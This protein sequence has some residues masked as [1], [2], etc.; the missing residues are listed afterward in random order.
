MISLVFGTRPEAIKLAP[1]AASLRRQ[2]VPFSV[3]CT[4]QHT[5]LL[6][7]I[8]GNLAGRSLKL[9]S[10][11]DVFKWLRHA[12]PLVSAALKSASA[13]VVVVQGDTMSALAGAR[14]ARNLGLTLCHV[15]AGIRS[16]NLQEPWPEEGFRREITRLAD[17]H[18]APTPTAFANLFAE[19]VPITRILVT[20]NTVVSALAAS[21]VVPLAPEPFLL[22]TMHRREWL[23]NVDLAKWAEALGEAAQKHPTLQIIWP[24]HPAVGAKWGG[25]RWRGLQRVGG[26]AIPPATNVNIIKPLS[27]SKMLDSLSKCQGLVT[28][29]GG[30]V[31]EAATLGIPTAI[32]R[33]YNDRP[34]AVEAG[35]ARQY[36]PSPSG[37]LEAITMLSSGVIE[38]EPSAA[39]GD[40]SAAE[41]VAQ[42]LAKLYNNLSEEV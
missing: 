11:G 25:E 21:G 15:E 28:D 26:V 27:H 20:G 23:A 10:Q 18:Y 19:G 7:G 30:L 9:P 12:A 34:E 35:I 33:R 36:D 41:Q 2:Q 40:A 39:Y 17:W 31:E 29:S 13:S 24:M 4:G 42:H 6:E 32:L 37:L 38:R 22:M 8:P 5:T 14:A 1:V 3:I 16:G